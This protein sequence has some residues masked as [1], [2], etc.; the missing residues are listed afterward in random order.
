MLLVAPWI[1]GAYWTLAIEIIF[2]STVFLLLYVN[3]FKYIETY[4]AVLLGISSA[5]LLA[6]ITLHIPPISLLTLTQHGCFFSLGITIWLIFAKGLTKARLS[7][8]IVAVVSGLCEI[9]LTD[10]DNFPFAPTASFFWLP[11]IIWLATIAF[12]F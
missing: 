1:D 12:I 8:V 11:Q 3:L 7:L 2:Y 10:F 6:R 4:A 9:T 5:Y